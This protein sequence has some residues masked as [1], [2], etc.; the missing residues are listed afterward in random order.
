MIKLLVSLSV[1]KE[2]ISSLFDI[3]ILKFLSGIAKPETF[4]L[5]FNKYQ[6]LSFEVIFGNKLK[7]NKIYFIILKVFKPFLSTLQ[8]EIVHIC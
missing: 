5:E 3:K 1:E 2:N 7:I 8:S 4:D 6:K